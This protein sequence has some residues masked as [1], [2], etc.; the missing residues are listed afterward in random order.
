MSTFYLALKYWINEVVGVV[1][2]DQRIA[3]GCYMMVAK[4]NIQI[5]SLVLE[6]IQEREGRGW[7]KT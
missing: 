4:E 3:I 7:T 1:K 6:K 5:T 2:G